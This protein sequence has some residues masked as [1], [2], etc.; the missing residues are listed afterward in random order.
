MENELDTLARTH[1]WSR[2]CPLKAIAAVLPD[3]ASADA[4]EVLERHDWLRPETAAL[5]PAK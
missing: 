4:A 2:R 1:P 3:Q 5:T